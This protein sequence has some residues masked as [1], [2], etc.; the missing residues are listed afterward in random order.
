MSAPENSRRS[1][2]LRTGEPLSIE[3]AHRRLH[4]SALLES[5]VGRVGIELENHVV[6]LA[7]T[8][9]SVR[10]D[11][12]S[13]LPADVSRAA[14]R[15]S[16][17]REPGG[18]LELSAPPRATLFAAVACLQADLSR[19]EAA[20]AQHGVGLAQVGTDPLR[21]PHRTNPSAR[22]RAMEEH[23]A[24]AGTA[25]CGAVTMNS[26]ASVQVN[27]DAGPRDSWVERV[28]RAHRL[29]PTLVAISANSPWLC[30]KPT[31]WKSARLRA[32]SG[33]DRRRC[34][35]VFDGPSRRTAPGVA[36]DPATAWASFALHAPVMFVRGDGGG[37]S[38]VRAN[39][40]FEEWVRGDVRLGGRL[41]E[42]ADLDLHLTTLFPPVRLR[43]YLELR[44]LDAT[45]SPWWPAIVTVAATLMDD[46]VAADLAAEVTERTDSLWA[47]AAR[48]GLADARL[49]DS[50][51]RCL[52]IAA[53]RVPVAM[54]PNV[55]ELE[56]LVASGRSPGD[57]L[58]RRIGKVGPERALAE[59]AR[60]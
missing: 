9:R 22:Y 54:R 28:A 32:W 60:R 42:S 17:S 53:D 4:E 31:G 33:L 26:T 59:L 45:P 27:L 52:R 11:T 10:W 3:D 21:P 36:T 7:A 15:N 46:P 12:I 29:G 47:R 37:L 16:V 58:A 43:G 40:T 55:V 5:P 23:F 51:T 49:A 35:P 25:A 41:P 2:G 14:G 13:P 18:Q 56:E 44:Y 30:G 50:A 6:D 1:G 20:L 19:V 34:R 24:A 57:L 48:D 8:A 39:V 38:A